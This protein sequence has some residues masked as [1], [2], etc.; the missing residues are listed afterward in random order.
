M[1]FYNSSSANFHIAQ[2]DNEFKT[3]LE[4]GTNLHNQHS[5][6]ENTE[7]T[8]NDQNSYSH[9]LLKSNAKY[10]DKNSPLLT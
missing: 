6:K 4:H 3:D 5:N 9:K 1:N 10:I 7:N 2:D 8:E